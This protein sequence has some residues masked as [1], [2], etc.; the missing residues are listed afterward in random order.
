MRDC[1]FE[2]YP[3]CLYELCCGMF[4]YQETYHP[5]SLWLYHRASGTCL[6]CETC[7]RRYTRDSWMAGTH[8]SSRMAVYHLCSSTRYWNRSLWRKNM[9]E[10]S[11]HLPCHVLFLVRLLRNQQKKKCVRLSPR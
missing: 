10:K 5:F 2:F 8:S 1:Q 4:E 6:P 7:F 9:V 3:Q 11:A